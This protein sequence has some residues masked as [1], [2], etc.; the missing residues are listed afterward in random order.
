MLFR[1]Q[2]KHELTPEMIERKKEAERLQE[3]AHNELKEAV[4]INSTLR[5][6]RLKNHFAEGFRRS[7][8][9][10]GGH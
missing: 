4:E 8:G 1:K 3:M 10:T 5:E 7:L 2:K 9:G 6:I